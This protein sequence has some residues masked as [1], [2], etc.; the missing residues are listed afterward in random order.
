MKFR[1][2]RWTS[3]Y[4]IVR[5]LITETE[6]QFSLYASPVEIDPERPSL[7]ISHPAAYAL[8]L[9]KLFGSFA[10]LGMAEHTGALNEKALDEQDFLNQAYS[11]FEERLNMFTDA[12]EK[13]R[14]G[15]VGCVFDTS[16]RIQHRSFAEEGSRDPKTCTC[17]WTRWWA[18]RYA[19]SIPEP[20]CSCCQTTAFAPSITEST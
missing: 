2:S 4:G 7:P 12:L 15:V 10:T 1:V 18:A 14:K 20:P 19:M 13:T 6:P 16:D 8:Y 5:F 9:A 11:I 17:A 3:V